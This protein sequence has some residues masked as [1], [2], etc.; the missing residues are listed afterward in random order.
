MPSSPSA[1]FAAS[2]RPTQPPHAEPTDPLACCCIVG[3]RPI[4]QSG[5]LLRRFKLPLA[6]DQA[7]W[8]P[9]AQLCG[10]LAL[11]CLDPT[12]DIEL[13]QSSC[14]EPEGKPVGTPGAGSPS[15]S[16]LD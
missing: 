1:S 8:Q 3:Y 13:S 9:F 7:R 15:G 2:R 6:S 11:A 4:S 16:R 5:T 10:P 12:A 14:P